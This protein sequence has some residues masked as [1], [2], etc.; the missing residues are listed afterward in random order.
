MR[1]KFLKFPRRVPKNDVV[2]VLVLWTLFAKYNPPFKWTGVSYKDR[3]FLF[4]RGDF[5]PGNGEKVI[6]LFQAR[7]HFCEEDELALMLF[8]Y[9]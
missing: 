4:N 9:T 2:S 5:F 7:R 8:C 6:G 1:G 3:S